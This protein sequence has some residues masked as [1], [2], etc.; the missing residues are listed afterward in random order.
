MHSA[1]EAARRG[2]SSKF[3]LGTRFSSVA[4]LLVSSDNAT[5][6]GRARERQRRIA[7]SAL[8]SALAKAISVSTALISVPLTLTYLGAERYGM[9]MTMSSLVAML[10]FAD[11]GIGNGLLASVAS[12]HGRNDRDEIQSYVSSAYLVLSAIAIAIVGLFFL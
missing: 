1:S 6:E 4:L 11:L 2:I 12:A 8:A 10:S 9:W 3:R 5:P 7:L